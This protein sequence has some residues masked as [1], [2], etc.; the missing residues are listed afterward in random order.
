MDA[1]S[2]RGDHILRNGEIL[3]VAGD[4]AETQ[5]LHDAPLH[6]HCILPLL[7]LVGLHQLLERRVLLA[8]VPP[9]L[10]L[11][12]RVNIHLLGRSIGGQ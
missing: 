7:H 6:D 5:I 1:H 2:P 8:V 3:D 12:H 11:R 9:A 10:L 4:P